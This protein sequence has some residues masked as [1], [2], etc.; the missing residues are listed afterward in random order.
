MS[1]LR[2]TAALLAASLT[3]F[4]HATPPDFVADP[5]VQQQAEASAKEAVGIALRQFNLKLDGGEGS[6]DDIER[7]LERLHGVY[8]VASPKPPDADLLPIAT[9]FGAYVGEVYRKNHGATWGRVTLNGNTYPGFRT[10]GGVDVWPVGR[11]LNVI[12][13]GPDND[14]AYFYR[15]LVDG[16][17]KD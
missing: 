2:L 8:A 17:A 9:A 14:I 5:A 10:A 13:D 16:P 1:R 6:I 7:A 15:K 3:S 12:T 4:V 11:V